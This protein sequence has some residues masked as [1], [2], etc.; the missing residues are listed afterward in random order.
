V[1][2]FEKAILIA[3]VILASCAVATLG[4]QIRQDAL[5]AGVFKA[6]HEAFS[7]QALPVVKFSRYQWNIG[8]QGLSCENPAFGINVY[9]RNMSLVPVLRNDVQLSFRMGDQPVFEEPAERTFGRSGLILAAGEEAA[10]GITHDEFGKYYARLRGDESTVFLSF[11]VKA[12]Y[13]SLTTGRCYQYEGTVTL[14]DDCQLPQQHHWSLYE[15]PIREVA[16]PEIP[17]A[18]N[19]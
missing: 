6:A 13:T 7:A 19:P 5:S 1:T 17:A 9:V 16:C 10:T 12:T 8:P 2:R 4:F 11:D 14:L 18:G 15:K 3:N